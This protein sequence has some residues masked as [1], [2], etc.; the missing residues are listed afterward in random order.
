MTLFVSAV[1][2]KKSWE[3]NA[4]WNG[5]YERIS[6]LKCASSCHWCRCSM[7]VQTCVHMC[8]WEC[9]KLLHSKYD[10]H[11]APGAAARVTGTS[12][13]HPELM[14][15]TPV[16]TQICVLETEMLT[17]MRCRES[18]DTGAHKSYP[19]L[20]TVA[21]PPFVRMHYKSKHVRCHMTVTLVLFSVTFLFFRFTVISLRTLA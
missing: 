2:K 8:V 15:N 14:T 17:V 11:A 19:R 10:Q 9:V 1:L 13:R 3:S 12:L 7:P 5:K 16:R 6:L 20:K 4:G 18:S 21:W